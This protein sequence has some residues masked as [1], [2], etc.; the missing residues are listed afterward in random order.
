MGLFGNNEKQIK[1]ELSQEMAH[2]C[3]DANKGIFEVME[4]FER[5]IKSKAHLSEEYIDL[6]EKIIPKLEPS[7]EKALTDFAEKLIEFQKDYH[8]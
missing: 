2:S 1:F 4:G 6:I 8:E 5:N 7:E 3:N